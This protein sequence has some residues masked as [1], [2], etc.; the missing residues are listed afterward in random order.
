MPVPFRLTLPCLIAVAMAAAGG[1]QA[2]TREQGRGQQQSQWPR[3]GQDAMGDSIRRVRSEA[4]GQVLSA[5]RMHMDGREINRIKVM[6]DRGRV[7]VYEDDPQQRVRSE[8]PRTR[9][10]DD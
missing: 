6:D 4:R 10:R 2:Q 9:S 5:E 1:A 7:R 8:S 3:G